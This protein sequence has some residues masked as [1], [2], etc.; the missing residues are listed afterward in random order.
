MESAVALSKTPATKKNAMLKKRT[1]RA[2]F[3]SRFGAKITNRIYSKGTNKF[4]RRMKQFSWNETRQVFCR[5]QIA[6]LVTSLAAGLSIAKFAECRKRV[7]VAYLRSFLSAMLRPRGLRDGE[8]WLLWDARK[9]F[10]RESG[11]PDKSDE[12]CAPLGG[13]LLLKLANATAVN[14]LAA[15]RACNLQKAGTWIRAGK[16]HNYC[17]R[18]RSNLWIQR[19]CNPLL[20][21]NW[22]RVTWL[23][24]QKHDWRH[25]KSGMQIEFSTD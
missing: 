18:S 24:S 12:C 13:L 23:N 21:P 15:P 9:K 1:D 19:E 14:Y 6:P 2:N 8:K 17:G 16:L 11:L 22:I 20:R 10:E 7:S 25:K 3:A 4:T 5:P